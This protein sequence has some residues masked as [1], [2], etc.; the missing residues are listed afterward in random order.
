MS[1]LEDY[2]RRYIRK[3]NR[4]DRAASIYTT[5]LHRFV[6][7]LE[8]REW[9]FLVQR[10]SRFANKYKYEFQQLD[11]PTPDETYIWWDDALQ[12]NSRMFYS[13]FESDFISYNNFK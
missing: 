13:D 1:D 6:R 4:I 9:W 7:N 2:S 8:L 12:A 10:F 11:I 3:L 5:T